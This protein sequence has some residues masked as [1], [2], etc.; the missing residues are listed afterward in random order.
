M[1]GG[2]GDLSKLKA[3]ARV[4]EIIDQHL[5]L[6]GEYPDYAKAVDVLKEKGVY[7]T[8]TRMLRSIEEAQNFTQ[9]VCCL[10]Q[11]RCNLFHGGKAPGDLRD[12][13]LVKAAH[14]ITSRIIECALQIPSEP[15]H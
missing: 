3:Y 8:A 14:I 9:V 1:H 11:V 7:D 10:Y 2:G 5:R 15:G 6:L 12:I 13:R 4:P